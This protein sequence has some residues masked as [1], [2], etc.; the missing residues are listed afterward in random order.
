MKSA[1]KQ[2]RVAVNSNPHFLLNLP[3]KQQQLVEERFSLDFALEIEFMCSDELYDKLGMI[4]GERRGLIDLDYDLE[5][6][7]E[8]EK[9]EIKLRFKKGIKGLIALYDVCVLL[10]K[11]GNFNPESGIHYNVDF[12]K[13]KVKLDYWSNEDIKNRYNHILRNIIPSVYR[14]LDNW[15]YRGDYNSRDGYGSVQQSRGGNWLFK[16]TKHVGAAWLAI[17][18]D[19]KRV[20]IRIGK[21]SFDYA[22]IIKRV[23]H[24]IK[25]TKKLMNYVHNNMEFINKSA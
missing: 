4:R 17:R 25:I 9:K 18:D 24:S 19:N 2:M 22:Y 14:E 12:T 3:Q 10:K 21:M 5:R 13:C 20:E 16:R 23:S 1:Y 15:K 8:N 11:Y 6:G 7:D